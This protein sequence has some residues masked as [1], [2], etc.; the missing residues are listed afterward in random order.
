MSTMSMFKLRFRVVLSLMVALPFLAG[1]SQMAMA[2]P[3]VEPL[4]QKY[5]LGCHNSNDKEGGLSLQ[6]MDELKAGGENGVVFD[7]TDPAKSI[8]AAV[9]SKDAENAMPPAD[10][11]QPTDA[12]REQLKQWVLSGARIQAMAAGKPNVP[13][14]KPFRKVIPSLLASAFVPQQKAIAVAGGRHVAL[15]DSHTKETKWRTTLDNARVTQLSV[16]TEHPWLVAASGM[17]GVSGKALLLDYSS[18]KVV[19]EFGGHTDAVYAAVINSKDSILA[20]AGYDRRILLHDVATGKVLRT[21]EGHNGSVFS[22]AFDYL[23]QILCSASADGTVKVWSVKTGERL[24]TLSQPQ[25][26]Q[27][28]VLVAPN[29]RQIIAA[30]ADNRIRIWQLVSRES[31]KINPLLTS[32]FAHEQPIHRMALS[33]DGSLLASAAEDGTVRVWT[34][35]PLAHH[36]I[37]PQQSVAVTSLTFGSNEQLFL[38]RIDGTS[39]ILPVKPVATER[40][41]QPASHATTA[42][43]IALPDELNEVAETE[44]N[45]DPETAQ[46]IT[47]PATVTGLIKPKGGNDRDADCFRFGAKAGQ[48]LVLEVKA[49][50]DKSPL[51]SKIE[52]LTADGGRIVRTQLQAVRDSYFTFRGKDSDTSDDFRVFNWQEM[53]LNEYL[54]ADGEVVKL[55]LYPRGPD[56]GYK[57]YP[58][59]GKRFTYF[60]TTPTSHALQAPCFIVVPH[61]PNE[62][63][64][65]NG[66]PVFPVYFEN[67]DDPRR[68]AG[69]DSRLLFTA[70]ANGDYV[71]RL[72]DARGFSG[73]DYRYKLTIRSPKPDFNV[74]VS[75]KKISVAKGT[76]REIVFTATRIDGYEGPIIINIEGLPE[77]FGFSGPI[78]IQ[79]GQL[80]AFGTLYATDVAK[81]PTPEDV[82]NIRILASS[83]IH[84]EKDLGTLEE[85]KLLPDSKLKATITR[86]GAA[87]DADEPLVLTIEPGQ[88]IQAT[89][90]LDRIKHNGVVSFGK[91]D[92]GRNL[93]HGVFVDN[94]GLNGLLLLSDQSEREFFITAAKWVPGTTC[95]FYLKSNIDNVTTLPV[96][97]KVIATD[98]VAPK[99][100]V[101]TR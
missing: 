73:E 33:A 1:N 47:L 88:T 66:L 94:I 11:A 38:T 77:G 53:E 28:T 78:E 91:E 49:Q 80:Q 7:A 20:T 60:D 43:A 68:A 59:F 71:V 39:E 48:Q 55:W 36:Q 44:G 75:T 14:V 9:L 50:Q 23:G 8:L 89:V 2:Q 25:A 5:C 6:T 83:E 90:K 32:Q 63:L 81:E 26:E 46:A 35:S 34:A 4:L 13:E 3:P 41:Q 74:A 54:Y 99:K 67:D 101:T 19:K 58:G 30:G 31:A 10:E 24:D 12:E 86:S 27:Y 42:T 87:T 45:N 21:L 29:G 62:E 51:D 96:T 82:S 76:G 79:A 37:L 61:E 22:L 40:S 93:P 56:S 65:P 97:L 84:G 52:V 57:V 69:S 98:D 85:L 16:A 18:G 17:P 72:T 15:I 95:T 64:T 92:S 100:Q 70:P